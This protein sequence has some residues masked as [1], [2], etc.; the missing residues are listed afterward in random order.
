MKRYSEGNSSQKSTYAPTE[1]SSVR[2]RCACLS[3]SGLQ[4]PQCGVQTQ[5][6]G[7]LVSESPGVSGP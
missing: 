7:V 1:H 5:S 3:S 2:I 6:F 4:N